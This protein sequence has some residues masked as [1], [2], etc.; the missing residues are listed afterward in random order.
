[1]GGRGIEAK[2]K[3][4]DKPMEFEDTPSSGFT[5]NG[6][7]K[8]QEEFFKKF[9]NFDDLI[10]EMSREEKDE[11]DDIWVPGAFMHGEGYKDW[12]DMD[13]WAQRAIEVYDK[14][15]DKSVL[16]KGVVVA[17][18]AT[19]ELLF[20][21]GKSF[22]TFDEFKAMEGKVI[23]STGN[24]STGAAKEGLTIGSTL[25][26]K[27]T[28]SWGRPK[29]V[30]YK[31]TIPSGSKGAGMWIGDY[32]INSGFGNDQREFMMNRDIR[33]RV[34]KTRYDSRRDVYVV[35]MTYEGRLPHR[36]K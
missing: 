11:F 20:G 15:L 33:L 30:E 10:N 16:T 31:I 26:T 13:R 23:I 5:Y 1:M 3:Q 32:R 25:S 35:E 19:G 8:K 34:G 27:P 21:K 22:G 17:R 9:S 29:S 12:N 24:M 4:N 7:G 36:Y 28:S 14:F 2:F 6:D 18:L